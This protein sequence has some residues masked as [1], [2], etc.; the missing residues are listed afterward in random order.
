MLSRPSEL[1]TH[2]DLVS[3]SEHDTRRI[4]ERLGDLCRPGDLIL[5]EG[6]LGAGKTALAQGIGRGLGVTATINSPTFTLVKEY[7]GRL[8]FYHVDLYRLD[9]PD[10]V[11][12]LGLDEYLE[13]GGVCVVEWADRAGALWPA[14]W[15]RMRLET[16]G[17]HE[18]HLYVQ[19]RGVRGEALRRELLSLASRSVAR[20][21]HE[22]EAV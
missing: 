10:E 8:P 3:R 14:S 6:Q 4:G 21:T 16:A 12:D 1:S 22:Q 11:A 13:R 7:A 9:G 15:L 20:P 17:P 5:L 2:A 19:G 18:R